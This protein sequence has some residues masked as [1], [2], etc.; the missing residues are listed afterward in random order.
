MSA[1]LKNG[2]RV[3]TIPATNWL[4]YLDKTKAMLNLRSTMLWLFCTLFE[5]I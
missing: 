2:Y 5:T 1:G 3:N 4:S